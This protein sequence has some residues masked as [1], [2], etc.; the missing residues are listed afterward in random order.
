[1]ENGAIRDEQISASS[2]WD[3]NH[4]AIQGRLHFRATSSKA[5]S[6]SARTNDVNQWIQI[7][8]RKQQTNITR[9]ATQGRNGHNQWVISY[10]L[11]Y[12]DDGQ[13][14]H[15]YREQGQTTDKV[16]TLLTK[17]KFLLSFKLKSR[18]I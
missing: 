4:A 7:D 13:N 10:K 8:L 1:M 17:V 14:F 12:S 5:G 16:K 2:Q 3:S 15:Y 18:E 11:Q 6:W 9:I